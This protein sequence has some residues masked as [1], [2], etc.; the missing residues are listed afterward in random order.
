[1]E[2][3]THLLP[4]GICQLSLTHF[5]IN[6]IQVISGK[7]EV[8]RNPSHYAQNL[9][10]SHYGL[11]TSTTV[12]DTKMQRDFYLLRVPRDLDFKSVHKGNV[13]DLR[14]S[15]CIKTYH[16]VLICWQRRKRQF[17]WFLSVTCGLEMPMHSRYTLCKLKNHILFPLVCM[18][19]Y[20]T[21]FSHKAK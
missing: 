19:A 15:L 4:P 5:S 17:A 8:A 6:R 10:V 2:W 16:T 1:M 21:R 13:W 20:E 7:R 11:S 18:H 9:R 14:G 12:I 3:I